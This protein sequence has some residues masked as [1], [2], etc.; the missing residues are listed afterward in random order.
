MIEFSGPRG[1]LEDHQARAVP[2]VDHLTTATLK[3][4]SGERR[5][6]LS[7][8]ND[9]GTRLTFCKEPLNVSIISFCGRGSFIF[10]TKRYKLLRIS[11]SLISNSNLVCNPRSTGLSVVRLLSLFL[12]KHSRFT[13][14]PA[15]FINF[16]S[17]FKPRILTLKVFE[18]RQRH[19]HWPQARHDQVTIRFT[20]RNYRDWRGILG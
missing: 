6:K 2:L 11:L 8:K 7:F 3:R 15:L 9:S 5:G 13:Y 18:E 20:A 4:N 16:L 19:T 12:V 17:D 1:Y 10:T 14:S